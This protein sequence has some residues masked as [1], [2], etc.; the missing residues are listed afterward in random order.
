MLMKMQ[1]LDLHNYWAYTNNLKINSLK[2]KKLNK[3]PSLFERIQFET[4]LKSVYF[5][6]AFL[7]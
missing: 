7:R 3:D 5:T 4:D 2:M 6:C 1:L